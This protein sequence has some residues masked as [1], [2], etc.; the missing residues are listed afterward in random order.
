MINLMTDS[1]NDATKFAIRGFEPF[2]LVL[3]LASFLLGLLIATTVSGQEFG[4]PV[5]TAAALEVQS[6]ELQLAP[7]APS[8][9]DDPTSVS[10]V[11][12]AIETLPPPL[13][14]LASIAPASFQD[15]NV[16]ILTRGTLHEAFASVHQANVEPAP[17]VDNVPP[18]PIDEVAPEYKPEGNN[19][20][21]IP[22]YWAWDDGQTDFIWI[23]G[24]WRDVP[25]GRQW[26]PG[27]WNEEHSQHRWVSGFWTEQQANEVGYLPQPPTSLD[28]GPSVQSPGEDH[29]YVPGNWDYQNGDYRWLS[30]HWQPVVKNWIWIPARY[31]WTPHGC[32]YVS[33]YWDYEVESRGTCFAPVHF[34]RPVYTQ[35]QYVYR[36][37]YVVDINVDF[38]THLFVRPRCGS[39][40]YGDWYNKLSLIHI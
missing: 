34:N 19:V 10:Q 37:S 15:E 14:D 13:D 31:A 29:F 6:D 26:V 40:F 7:S 38:L 17:L 24:V 16:E 28:N 33:G 25:P 2:K 1:R 35:Q 5:T 23:S 12:P 3:P 27:Y 36:P 8:A 21:W 32:V 18:Q 39:Y 30:G 11:A 20:Q 22:G 9:L 4:F